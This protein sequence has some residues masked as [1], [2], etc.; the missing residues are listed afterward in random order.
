MFDYFIHHFNQ[1]IKIKQTPNGNIKYKTNKANNFIGNFG[2]I[3]LC[4]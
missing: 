2:L 3:S 4:G 1:A